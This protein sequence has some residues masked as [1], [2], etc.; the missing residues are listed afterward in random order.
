MKYLI[1]EMRNSGGGSAISTASVAGLRGVGYLAAYSAAKAAVVNL[2]Q[3]V[4]IEGGHD[5]IR[6]NCICPGGVNTP[7]IH[8]GVPSGAQRSGKSMGRMQPIPRAGNP[9]DISS[10]APVLAGSAGDSV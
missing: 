1:P 8:R 5:K 7:L 2:T 3:A 4:A 6:V 9:D 10:H